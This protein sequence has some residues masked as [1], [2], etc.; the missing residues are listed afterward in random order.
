MADDPL[1]ILV[2]GAHPDDPENKAG[3]VAAKYA[4]QG[5][6]V[7]FVAL[8]NGATGHHGIGGIELARRRER[9]ARQASAVIGAEYSI[10]DN[11]T[12]ELLPTIPNRKALIRMIREY[13]PDLLFTH[14]P[15]DYHPDHRYTAMLVR[16]SA[17]ILTVPNMCPLTPALDANPVIVYL[18]D[19][20]QKPNPFE[21]DVVVDI[22]DAIETKIEML[23]QHTSQMYEWLPYNQ[24]KLEEVPEDDRARKEW[25]GAERLPSYADIADRYRDALIDRYGEED[26]SNVEY[27]E[28]FE[29]C[30]YGRQPD[31]DELVDLFPFE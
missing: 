21:P 1:R 3:G 18:S 26:G 6:H 31:D 12:G 2:I 13:D 10:V 30:E 23:H 16:D 17:Y 4:R 25:L 9:E 19:T 14:R 11:H 15:N 8:T 27:A 24:N 20:F 22:D 7:R 28:A 5:H 29:V